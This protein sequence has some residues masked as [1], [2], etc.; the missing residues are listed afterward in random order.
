MN[1]RKLAGVLA[2]TLSL[3]FVGC[4]KVEEANTTNGGS[5]NS[6]AQDSVNGDTD[7]EDSVPKE[8]REG[9]KMM[10]DDLG[11]WVEVKQNPKHISA[12]FAVTTHY[13]AM[14]GEIDRVASIS[15]GNTRDYLFCEIF[16]QVLEK[17]IVKGNNNINLEEMVSDPVPEMIFTNPEALVDEST[18]QKLRNLGI[19]IYVCSFG[20]FKEQ[21]D[22]TTKLA[23]I[24]NCE[25]EGKLYTDYY[26]HIIEL[27]ESRVKTVPDSEKKTAYHAI[28]ELL[29]TDKKGTISEEIMKAAGAINVSDDILVDE[30]L[31]LTSKSYV[32]IEELMQ[33]NP[34]YIFIN[35]ADVYD[36]IQANSQLHSLRAFKEDKIVLLPLGVSRWGHPN[37][38]ETPLATLFV[39]K[40]LYPEL[41]EDI[42]IEDEIKTFYETMFNYNLSDEQIKNI[43]EGRVYKDIKGGAN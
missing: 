5:D 9:Y 27:V 23:E 36:Y 43:I 39:A 32:G 17:R 33:E 20:T 37:S 4:D 38:I 14:F 10:E 26:S 34:E 15:E 19:P 31:T 12:L 22:S 40:T 28:N 11:N 35:G 13:M 30:D 6:S 25:E 21:I 41:F 1:Y 2:L 7:K 3:S 16:P 8:A 42:S 24:M 29:R 18:A